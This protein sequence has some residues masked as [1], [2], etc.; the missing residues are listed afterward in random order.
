[1]DDRRMYLTGGPQ[2]R[3]RQQPSPWRVVGLVFGWISLVLGTLGTLYALLMI[4]PSQGAGQDQHG[5]GLIFGFFLL[6]VSALF[7]LTGL[8][9]VLPKR[10][11]LWLSR[12]VA[13][14]GILL[15]IALAISLRT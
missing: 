3:M 8:M 14:L 10:A 6:I 4:V 12:I 2:D 11:A 15:I 9:A 7:L 5:Y 1:M 13:V